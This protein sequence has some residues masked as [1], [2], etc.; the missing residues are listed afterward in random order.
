MLLL[1]LLSLIAFFETT[2]EI[3]CAFA[4]RWLVPETAANQRQLQISDLMKPKRS[5]SNCLRIPVLLL[6]DIVKEASALSCR[7][8][9]LNYC[10]RELI[11]RMCCC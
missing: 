2:L 9:A 5:C 4:G 8:F 10:L 11:C 7:G 6:D 1:V 3:V